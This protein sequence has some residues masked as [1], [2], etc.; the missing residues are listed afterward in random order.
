MSNLT[1]SNTPLGAAIGGMDRRVDRTI[2]HPAPFLRQAL[3]ADA[4]T[5]LATG[6]LMVGA[7]GLLSDLLGLPPWLLG[8][9]GASLIPFAGAV[10]YMSSRPQ[11]PG[12]VVWAVIACNAIWALASVLLLMSGWFEPT[13]A[14]YAFVIA[15]A[16][17]VAMYAELQ[18][19]GLRKS[20]NAG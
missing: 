15:Q 19:V 6:L 10:A 2:R 3:L 5:S 1:H 12:L 11:L 4:V 8:C 16:V 18:F 13:R 14:G 7:T 20:A 17:V 9:A